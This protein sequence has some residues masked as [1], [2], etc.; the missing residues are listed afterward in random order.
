MK[1]EE[2]AWL[3]NPLL[4]FFASV[5][6]AMV[7]LAVLIVATIAG[8]I[9][10]SSFDARVARAYI[11]NASWFNFWLL[12]LSAN[13]IFSAFSRMPWKRHHTGFLLTHLG[14][15]VLL[16]GALIG[17][18]WGVEGSM[19]IFK[20][21]PPNHLLTV[22]QHVLQVIDGD[23]GSQ[24]VALEMI[25]RHPSREHPWPLTTTPSG[26][27]ISAVDYSPAL[28]VKM[29]PKAVGEGGTAAI[30]FTIK[31]A[32]MGQSMDA[33]LMADGGDH[34]SFD[35]GL[36]GVDFK[37]GTAAA[38]T[39]PALSQAADLEETIFSFANAAAGQVSK[40]I[41]GGS[42]G[43]K[44]QLIDTEKGNS[45]KVVVQIGAASQ[46][47]E[48]GAGKTAAIALTPFTARIEE[49]WPD[50]RI[51]DG[52]PGNAS[53]NPN[54]PCV[55]VTI[56]GHAAP[57]P[58]AATED[59]VHIEAGGGAPSAAEVGGK[60]RL[61]LY[62][63]AD[64]SLS[65]ELA[66][67]MMGLSSGK[68]ELNKPLRTGWADWTLVADQFIPRAE[69]RYD[70]HPAP[71][72]ARGMHAE[73]ILARMTKGSRSIEQ[74]VPLGWQVSIPTEP[75]PLLVGYGNKQVPLPIGL[76]L[77]DFQVDWNEGTDTPAGF[78]STLDVVDQETGETVTGQCWMNHPMSVPDSWWN[79]FTG[80][81]YKLSQASW[82]PQ[83]LSQSSIQ[84]LRDPG[85]S[86]K[87]TG[88]LIIVTGIFS[89]F[90]L[91]P[92]PMEERR[93]GSKRVRA[94]QPGRTRVVQSPER[95][96]LPVEK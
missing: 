36:A 59:G 19:T 96:V 67:R 13:L 78:K 95:R 25:N 33:W 44:V 60:N 51:K 34:A 74:W 61:T 18:M 55:L 87:W 52:K 53:A 42:T 82:N 68:L 84:I 14:I 63:A 24:T 83:N 20:G 77:K 43:A 90:Y 5:K 4:A 27:A 23:N 72:G 6:L 58:Q 64:G 22:D 1:N 47:I 46:E 65:Y 12:L 73:G 28:D 21:D 30:H 32:R 79:T 2:P 41:K 48:V 93:N 85:W 29:A 92:Y 86:L 3:Q 38:T 35:M 8:T 16:A 49:Y 11:Y 37:K 17:R 56:S 89:L 62:V 69:E 45:P 7:L 91:R 15:I 9:Y 88:S 71:E 80:L 70:A 39:T 54:N 81:T 75:K 40:V 50:F 10:E 31:T 76:Q 57:V 66:S 26:W 94:E